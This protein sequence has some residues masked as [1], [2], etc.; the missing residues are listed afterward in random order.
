MVKNSNTLSRAV[1]KNDV[2]LLVPSPLPSS[3][4]L[5]RKFSTLFNCFVVYVSIS[6]FIEVL[7]IYNVLISAV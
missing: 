4:V 6:F 2:F 7:W 5:E 1:M 3:V